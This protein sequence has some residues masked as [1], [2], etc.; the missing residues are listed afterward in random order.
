MHRGTSFRPGLRDYSNAH[1]P[2]TKVSDSKEASKTTG[3][4]HRERQDRPE[5]L[6]IQGRA[7]PAAG[8]AVTPSKA[9]VQKADGIAPAKSPS[10]ISRSNYDM[11]PKL[12]TLPTHVPLPDD[13][14]YGIGGKP[15]IRSGF[16]VFVYMMLVGWMIGYMR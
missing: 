5:Q 13:W 3:S 6:S 7:S 10:T 11:N 15:T 9:Y 14:A 8:S 12:Q 4:Q 16:I 2:P 1:K